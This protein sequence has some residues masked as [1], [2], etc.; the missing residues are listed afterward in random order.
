MFL[1]RVS[2]EPVFWD[3]VTELEP[4][5]DIYTIFDVPL[6]ST[7]A[8]CDKPRELKPTIETWTL[9]KLTPSV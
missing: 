4:P 8:I 2:F 3:N 1:G 5:G 7:W 6:S 9:D